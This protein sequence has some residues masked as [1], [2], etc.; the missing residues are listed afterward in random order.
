MRLVVLLALTSLFAMANFGMTTSGQIDTNSTVPQIA[1]TSISTVDEIEAKRS[2]L[3]RKIFGV[4]PVANIELVQVEQL[5]YGAARA[6]RFS[7]DL[8][9]GLHSV[10]YYYKPYTDKESDKL[11]IN[12][13]GHE[14]GMDRLRV[15]SAAILASGYD[16][17]LLCMPLYCENGDGLG[18][19]HDRL[20][21]INV[22]SG[23]PM[24]VFLDPVV[25]VA[26]FSEQNNK[27][28]Y[29]IGLSGGGWTTTLMAAIEPRIRMSFPV[30][31]SLPFEARI[32]PGDQ[33][34][35]EQKDP[36]TYRIV[37]YQDLYLM[38]TDR[39]RTHIQILNMHDPCCFSGANIPL[40]YM[41]G[42][43]ALSREI[44]GK[45]SLVIDD[46]STM[47]QVSPFSLNTIINEIKDEQEM[48]YRLLFPYVVA[49]MTAG[50]RS[51]Q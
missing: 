6:Y 44:G 36:E 47:H 26:N 51:G 16:V 24:R 48:Q 46:S 33:G 22:R 9:N 29:M 50:S 37:G 35:W 11:V 42:I 14:D 31:G 23:S 1:T 15:M 41:D 7:V 39:G 3:V 43:E 13:A 32:T 34:D 12:H 28:L 30:A 4:Y 19:S 5:I 49:V 17:A 40:G 27:A 38:A 21:D 10:G 8:D 45:Y 20:K 25:Q 2:E 18:V